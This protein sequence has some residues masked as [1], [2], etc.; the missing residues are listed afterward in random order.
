L[1][2]RWHLSAGTLR[3]EVPMSPLRLE[4]YV[5]AIVAV[6]L[7]TACNNT[8]GPPARQVDP[9]ALTAAATQIQA[10]LEAPVTR[11]LGAL[12]PYLAQ[13]RPAGPAAPLI[14]AGRANDLTL[15]AP[16]MARLVAPALALATLPDTLR[17]KTLEYSCATGS[18]AATARPGAP[19][20]AVRF[21]LYSTSSNGGLIACPAVEI[22]RAD[23]ADSSAGPG[24]P[25]LH[26]VAADQ[27]GT[28]YVDYVVGGSASAPGTTS[29][30]AS[31][32]VSDGTTPL[33]F[34][35]TLN[36]AV[37]ATALN[38]TADVTLVGIGHA[39]EL[40]E[41]DDISVQNGSG[42]ENIDMTMKAGGETARL[43]GPN[44]IT[45][46]TSSLNLALSLDG[47]PFATVTGSV[48]AP[49]FNGPDGKALTGDALTAAQA[50][51]RMPIQLSSD[52]GGLLYP[53]E[54][55]LGLVA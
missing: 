21:M 4:T 16:M 37:S 33:D 19:A 25:G 11:S 40:T 26:V 28:P 20:A 24:Q 36:V 42:R 54:I 43:V 29:L 7:V 17:G 1:T 8:A 22:G 41:H 13:F 23:F 44:T 31:G 55:L 39:I 9:T 48:Q 14:A 30:T 50:I 6:L 52:L 38:G 34:H 12:T 15:V 45:S 2:G 51:F 3:L 10:G 27:A 49:S 18:Y 47:A 35:L 32:T 5:H 46:S 53:A